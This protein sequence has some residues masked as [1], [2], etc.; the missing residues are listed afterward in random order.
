MQDKETIVAPATS[1]GESAVALI[2]VSGRLV[3]EI[4]LALF[5]R[6]P[7]PRHSTLG[8]YRDQEGTALDTLLYVYFEA[9]KSFT[10]EATLELMPHGNPWLVRKLI[11]DLLARGCSLAQPGAFTRQAFTNG[12]LDLTQAEAI[13]QLIQAR[14]DRALI[15]AQRQ[16]HGSVGKAI[17]TIL[18]Q[19]LM[20]TAEVEASIDF[21]EEDLPDNPTHPTLPRLDQLLHATEQLI[22]TRPYSALVHDGIKCVILGE[23][24]VGKSSLLNALTGEDRALVSEIPGTTRDYIEERIHLG[25]YLLRVIDTAG[26]HETAD[27]LEQQGIRRSLSQIEN[28]DL[29]LIVVDGSQRPPTLPDA[30][31]NVLEDTTSVIVHNKADLPT[32]AEFLAWPAARNAV[33][34]SALNQSGLNDLRNT[35]TQRVEDG[36]RIPDNDAILVSARHADALSHARQALLSA[37]DKLQQD[38]P[39]ELVA[40]DLRDALHH[41]EDILGKVDNERMLDHL[42]GAFCIGK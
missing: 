22:A 24:N 31:Q 28:A 7:E 21:P 37:R 6:I 20:A 26:L 41:L 4:V 29:L 15:A 40:A 17:Q 27:L 33:A 14:S 11:D 8:T 34:V 13:M 25:P 39:P 42:F 1:G 38:I 10:G 30:I 18:D 32:H 19:L 5:G 23:P 3:P 9:G 12:Q 35:L 2:R 36:I 16:L